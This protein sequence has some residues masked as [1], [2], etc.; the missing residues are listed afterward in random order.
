MLD[1]LST[2]AQEALVHFIGERV[3]EHLA[4]LATP[5]PSSPWLTVDEAAEHLRT[6]PGAIR[7]R[8]SRGQ[9]RAHRPEGSRIMLRRDELDEAL[10][11]GT[12][13]SYD[14][15]IQNRMGQRREHAL[16]PAPGG[17]S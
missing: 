17:K 4:S 15:T 16:A 13:R 1:L 8:I 5:S 10:D 3:A 2:S 9:L 14:L 12:H 11:L 6:T 7:K